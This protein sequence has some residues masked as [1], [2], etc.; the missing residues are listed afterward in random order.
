MDVQFRRTHVFVVSHICGDVRCIDGL[1]SQIL[2]RDVSV[3]DAVCLH[4]SRLGTAARDGRN[5]IKY[6]VI[7]KCFYGDFMNTKCSS[8][9][10]KPCFRACRFSVQLSFACYVER[11]SSH[12]LMGT[13]G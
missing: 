4:N 9:E 8:T 6:H 2:I 7:Q 5:R 3:G 1:K 10:S 12:I 13:P 11:P